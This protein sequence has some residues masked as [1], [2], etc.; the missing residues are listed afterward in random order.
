MLSSHRSPPG[1]EGPSDAPEQISQTHQIE[2]ARAGGPGEA[3]PI[4]ITGTDGDE[5]QRACGR[6]WR[7]PPGREWRV[8][9]REWRVPPRRAPGAGTE[10]SHTARL[11]RTTLSLLS[12]VTYRDCLPQQQDR[13]AAGAKAPAA[14]GGKA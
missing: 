9:P 3:P 4:E 12:L 1:E 10:D 5:E 11:P 14:A 8:P 2:L 6:E 13:A 7:V